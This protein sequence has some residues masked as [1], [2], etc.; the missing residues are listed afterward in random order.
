M[1]KGVAYYTHDVTDFKAAPELIQKISSDIGAPTILVNNAGIHLKK[2]ALKIEEAEFQQVLDTHVLGSMALTRAIVPGMMNNEKGSIIFIS[3]M[4]AIFGFPYIAAY[5]AAK[6][7]MLGLVR[8]LSIEFALNGIRVNAIAPGWIDSDMMRTA[9]DSD[10]AR[11]QKVLSRTPMNRFGKPDDI[12]QAAVYLSSQRQNLSLAS[13]SPSM[14]EQASD[15]KK[16]STENENRS[17][18]LQAPIKQRTL[19]ICTTNWCNAPGHSS[20]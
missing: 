7:A 18:T 6:S 10:P 17:W 20:R 11:K 15:S 1:G 16:E 8:V 14:A 13:N 12:G 2:P 3:S 19:S 4:A 5:S 9:L